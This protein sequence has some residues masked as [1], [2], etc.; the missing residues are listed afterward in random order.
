MLNLPEF[1]DKSV[2]SD[3]KLMLVNSLAHLPPCE[4][5]QANSIKKMSNM[6]NFRLS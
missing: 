5:P 1:I 3:E 2:W 6:S 4:Q